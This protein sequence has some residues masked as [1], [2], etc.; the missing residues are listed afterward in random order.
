MGFAMG[1]KINKRVGDKR[2][3]NKRG[4]GGVETYMRLL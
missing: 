1:A 3:P 2:V 4:E